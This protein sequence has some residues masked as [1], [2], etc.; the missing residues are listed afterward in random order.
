MNFPCPTQLDHN[1]R[2]GAADLCTE[3]VLGLGDQAIL[4]LNIY[5]LNTN[6]VEVVLQ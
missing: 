3:Y 6:P 2:N 4:K 1:L 5:P